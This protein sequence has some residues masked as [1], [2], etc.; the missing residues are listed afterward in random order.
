MLEILGI[1]TLAY[2]AVLLFSV[3]R[4]TRRNFGLKSYES[5]PAPDGTFVDFSVPSGGVW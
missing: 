4:R 2:M 1:I 3:K 5:R